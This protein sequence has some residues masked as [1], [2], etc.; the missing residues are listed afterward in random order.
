MSDPA[1]V[2]LGQKK[3][4]SR[5]RIASGAVDLSLS[6]S[7]SQMDLN[8][9]LSMRLANIY[10]WTLDFHH[11]RKGDHF[12]IIFEENFV[13]D[14]PIGLNK[15][16][17]VKFNHRAKDYHAFCFNQKGREEYYDENGNSLQ[18]EFLTA[19]LRYT[20]ITSRPQETV[21]IRS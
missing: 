19:P 7:F 15:I 20:R 2:Y 6:Q 3:V 17:A 21:F 12:V 18:R 9:D 16:V 13:E 11:L 10:A 1:D 14:K 5:L 4:K 8:F